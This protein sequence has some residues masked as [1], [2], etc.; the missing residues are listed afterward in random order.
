M[1]TA[2]GRRDRA[3]LEAL[4]T[5]AE[6]LGQAAGPDVTSAFENL[7]ARTAADY[8]NIGLATMGLPPV[9]PNGYVQT[10]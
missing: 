5:E 10:A 1:K 8:L 4:L 9:S 7:L 2:R 6:A 3:L